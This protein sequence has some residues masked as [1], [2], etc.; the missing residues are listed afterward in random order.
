MKKLSLKVLGA[1]FIAIGLVL[2]GVV[3]PAHAAAALTVST[4]SFST[5]TAT[6]SGLYAELTGTALQNNFDTIVIGPNSGWTN[7]NTCPV[8]A[9]AT[10]GNE[11]ACGISS[12]T[13]GTTPVTGW[14]A[15]LENGSGPRIRLYKL[16]AGTNFSSGDAIKVTFA[17]SAWTTP[18]SAAFSTFTFTTMYLGG[19][20]L[21]SVT[22]TLTVGSPTS[23]V[24]F[25]ANG[26]AGSMSNQTSGVTANLTSNAFTKAGYTFGGWAAS[27]TL[28][29]AG[30]VF[31]A[32][33]ASYDFTSSRTL[34][35]IWT[36][37]G[38]G[39]GSGGSGSS[40]TTDTLA[41]TGFDAAPYLSTGAV[42]ALAGAVLI[43][44]ARRRQTS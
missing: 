23:T 15:Y 10:A 19:S 39:G 20:N 7:I 32:N 18:S 28:A 4:T 12:I 29:N 43:L 37:S 30:T 17:S 34:Y 14:K 40:T 13:I 8:F 2:A 24:T 3:A 31:L 33:G 44:F 25:N 35:A 41:S 5:S 26:G 16:N 11:S 27:Q 6:S 36:P 21:D 38:S 1:T 9:N 42:L 22:T